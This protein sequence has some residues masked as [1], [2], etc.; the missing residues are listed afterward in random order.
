MQPSTAGTS[1]VETL[2]E[3]PA[4]GCGS[5]TCAP[6]W[7]SPLAGKAVDRP[8]VAGGVVYVVARPTSATGGDVLE[9]F[10]VGCSSGCAPLLSTSTGL[11]VS[12]SP[13]VT[14]RSRLFLA[15]AAVGVDP[16]ADAGRLVAYGPA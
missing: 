11:T 12:D 6:S 9:A 5:P 1:S 15:G 13:V 10:D 4:A 8:M 14:T 3:R 16:S 7:S 2:G